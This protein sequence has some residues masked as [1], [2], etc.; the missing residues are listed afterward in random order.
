MTNIEQLESFCNRR[1]WKLHDTSRKNGLVAVLM[2]DSPCAE[3]VRIEAVPRWIER[4]ELDEKYR[5]EQLK[6]DVQ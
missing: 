6:L 1:G 5:L 2:T 3:W 4:K